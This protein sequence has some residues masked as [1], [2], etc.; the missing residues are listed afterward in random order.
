MREVIQVN[1]CREMALVTNLAVVFCAKHVLASIVEAEPE[2]KRSG[3]TPATNDR[4]GLSLITLINHRV[5]DK[6]RQFGG[7]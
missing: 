5:Q 7:H 4:P 2:R 1:A 6:D 3:A